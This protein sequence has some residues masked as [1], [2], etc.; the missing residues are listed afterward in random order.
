MFD[1][2][3]N[4]L[5]LMLPEILREAQITQ[6][7]SFQLIQ[8]LNLSLDWISLDTRQ[9]HAL[10]MLRKHIE[11]GDILVEHKSP[12]FAIALLGY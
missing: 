6:R 9:S 4:Y 7:L 8:E 1:I 11:D 5:M 10:D 2:G 3:R 12:E